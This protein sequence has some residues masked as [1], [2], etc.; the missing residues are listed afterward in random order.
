MER[1]FDID[2][3]EQS[4]LGLSGDRIAR[5][6]GVLGLLVGF[7]VA[8]SHAQTANNFTA[9]IHLFDYDRNQ[10]LDVQDQII[11]ETGELAIHDI[12][13]TSPSGGPVSAYLVVP[14]GK[15]PFAGVLFAHHGL[16]TRS[17]FLPEAKLYAKAGAVSLMPDYPWD[18]PR[19]WRKSVDN[20][21]KPELDRKIF[22]QAIVELRRGIDLLLARDDVDSKRIA[23]VGHSMGAQWG[24]I[25][26][27]IDQRMR[28]TVLMAGVAEVGDLLLR[29][30]NPDLIDL[31][32]NQPAG[33][34]QEY[35]QALGDLD[36]IRFVGHASPTELLLQFANFERYFDS[37]SMQHYMDVA[38]APKKVIR[39]DSGHELNDPEALRDRY[40]W[41]VKAIGI[42]AGLLP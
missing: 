2:A 39:Y 41:L 4:L 18:R 1:T 36:A 11:E 27:A 15:G 40:H 10:P 23:Y 32:N 6:L 34:L 8:Q 12:T 28:A 37:T 9:A 29:S 38:T 7:G 26:S 22:I 19:P 20:F 17:E 14:K 35:C 42:K 16:G 31:R 25:L 33:Q 24:S 5:A 30:S 21:D 13:Y 3:S